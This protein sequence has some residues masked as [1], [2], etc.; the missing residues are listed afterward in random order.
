MTQ[1]GSPASNIEDNFVKQWTLENIKSRR[2]IARDP[3]K[4]LSTALTQIMLKIFT[5]FSGMLSLV[6]SRLSCYSH[7]NVRRINTRR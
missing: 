7:P 3:N 6:S 1:K 5:I 2:R 4:T